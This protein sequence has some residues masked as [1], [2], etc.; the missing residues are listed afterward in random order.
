[1]PSRETITFHAL[2]DE[3]RRGI[4]ELLHHGSTSVGQLVHR[5]DLTQPAVSQHLRVLREAGLVRVEKRGRQR[6][7]SLN[8]ESLHPAFVWLQQ[9]ERFWT[10]RLQSLGD[11]LRRSRG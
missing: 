3:T 8:P 9:Y 7:Y 5:F 6:V 4:L 1:V 10:A 11:H 2:S